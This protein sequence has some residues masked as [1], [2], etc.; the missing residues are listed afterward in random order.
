[1]SQNTI[2]VLHTSDW[3]LGKTLADVDRTADYRAFLKWLLG[4]IEARSINV[5]LVAGDIFDTTM[6][7]AEAQRL[8][9]SFLTEAAKTSLR[10]IVITAGNHD[11]QRFLRAPRELLSVVRTFVAG[12]T[13]EKEVC[14]VRDKDGA[15]LLG[16]AAVPYL[17]EGDVRLSGENDT[18]A[19]RSAAWGRGIGEHY[20]RA[21]EALK[22]AL[23]GAEVPMIVSGHL[24]V[25]GAKVAGPDEG[26]DGG[27]YVGS[28]RNVSAAVFGNAWDYVAL[29]HIH[30]AQKVAAEIPVRYSGSP[31]AL[32][33]GGAGDR[34]VVVELAFDGKNLT[35]TEI[36]VPQ[37]RRVMRIR[38]NLGELMAR[39]EAA[40]SESPGAI[41]EAIYEGDPMDAGI[42]VSE[43]GRAAGEAGVNLSAVRPKLLLDGTG[44]AGPVKSLDDISPDGVFKSVL[45]ANAVTEEEREALTPIFL[46]A[47]ERAEILEREKKAKVREKLAQGE[48]SA[49]EDVE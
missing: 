35:E 11:S 22:T 29:G 2:R 15:P 19:A 48:K 32:D 33:I 37:P 46:E 24:F 16:I 28:L 36:E 30:R 6:P 26:S 49:E 23:S 5:L 42:L 43:L 25:T 47:L 12:S 34:H 45:E 4:I 8:Y 31:L 41:L 10:Q 39:I 1:M 9:Y 17:R 7:S 3:H 44:D 14:V 13:A 21:L 38:G 27:V 20:A 40:G 18:D